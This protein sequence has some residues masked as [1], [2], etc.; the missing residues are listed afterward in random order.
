M[1]ICKKC[2]HEIKPDALY[3]NKCGAKI[4]QDALIPDL[5][6]EESLELVKT[7]HTKYAEILDLENEI[8]GCETKLSRPLVHGRVPSHMFRYFWKFLV[9][10]AIAVVVCFWLWLASFNSNFP[11]PEALFIFYSIIPLAIFI[12]GFIY[13]LRRTKAE[14]MAI[15]EQT[16]KEI[17]DRAELRKKY[18]EFQT[19]LD[20][21]KSEIVKLDYSIPEEYRNAHSIMKLKYLLESGKASS[22]KDAIIFIGK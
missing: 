17:Q 13:S 2:G 11:W 5:S 6:L 20:E 18:R 3:C 4:E 10:S 7:L 12:F 1:S 15:D 21:C 8:S 19:R 9:A 22:L 14:A 16:E